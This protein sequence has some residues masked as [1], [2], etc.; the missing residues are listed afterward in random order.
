MSVIFKSRHK[1]CS[2]QFPLRTQL[3][4]LVLW[5]ERI[6]STLM[7]RAERT[8]GELVYTTIPSSAWVLQAE[9]RF[10]LPSTSTTQTRQA[11]I[12][13]TSLR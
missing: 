7:R 3:V 5:L 9:Q 4:Q 1:L 12:S 11:P 8:L 6:S 2:V 13:L 10:S